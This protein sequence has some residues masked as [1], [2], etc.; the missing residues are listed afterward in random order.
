MRSGVACHFVIASTFTFNGNINGNYK[1]KK[2]SVKSKVKSGKIS[3][4]DKIL[5]LFKTSFS[6]S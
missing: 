3:S 6:P 5:G 2:I 1:T 4:P